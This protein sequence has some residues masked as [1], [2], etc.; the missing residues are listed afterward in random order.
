MAEIV[1]LATALKLA[2]E[3]RESENARVSALRD[4]LVNSV[5]ARVP[6]SKL[7]GHPTKRLPNN[8]SFAIRGVEGE[9]VLLALDLEGICVSTG[10][11]CTT[12]EAEPSFVLM[13]MGVP[14][15]W[16]VGSL[17][18][19]LGHLTQPEDIDAVLDVLPGIVERLRQHVLLANAH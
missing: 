2:Q 7:T 16:A 19:T 3:S 12:G 18:M 15:E 14:R 13:A 10:S 6:D 9:S 8:A 17:R 5:L 11:A 4:G 1:G